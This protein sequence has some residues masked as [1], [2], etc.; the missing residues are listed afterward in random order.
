VIA[1][2]TDAQVVTAILA[3]LDLPTLPPPLAPARAPP[4]RDLRFVISTEDYLVD[5]PP[6]DPA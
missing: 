3:H 1:F 4:Q 6:G 2:I 5:P